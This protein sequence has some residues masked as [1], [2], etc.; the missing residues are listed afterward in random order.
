MKPTRWPAFLMCMALMVAAPAAAQ[1]LEPDQEAAAPAD[2]EVTAVVLR[3]FP[4]QFYMNRNA[5]PAGFA[6][7]VLDKV[8]ELAHLRIRYLIKN[9][10]EEA[11]EALRRGEGQI[12]PNMAMLPAWQREFD[13]SMPVEASPVS[14]FVL[15]T[16]KDIRATADLA[17]RKVAAVEFNAP[18]GLFRNGPQVQLEIFDSPLEGL[19]HLLAG[20]MDAFVYPQATLLGLA[21]RIGVDHR[22]QTVD[23]PL[24]QL[25]RA[26][27]LR[28]GNLQ[29]RERLDAALGQLVGGPEFKEIYRKW[30]GSPHPFWTISRVTW[31]MTALLVVALVVMALWR[32]LSI[33]AL[34]R[35]LLENIAVRR[36]AEEA[37]RDSEEKYRLVVEN[38]NEAIFVVQEG[39]IRFAN[40]VTQELTGYGASEL[41]NLPFLELVH[42]AD[43]EQA[44]GHQGQPAAGSQNYR[45]VGRQR[46]TRWVQVN[47]VDISWGNRPARLLLARDIT[48]QRTRE[49][50]AR[51]RQKIED[52]GALAGSVAHD[53]NKALGIIHHNVEM[54]LEQ[55]QPGTLSQ[56]ALERSLQAVQRSKDLV[57]EILTFRRLGRTPHHRLEMQPLVEDSLR[58]IGG[59]LPAG[60]GLTARLE[61]PGHWIEGDP[62]QV[63]Q[64]LMNLCLNAAQAIGVAGG[65]IEVGLAPHG[66]EEGRE[67]LHPGLTPGPYLLLSVRDTGQG[68]SPE[69]LPKI[70]D[71]FFTTKRPEEG[72]GLG[73][74][75]V[76]GIVQNH[77]GQVS[78]ESR[79]GQGTIFRLL[80]PRCQD[81]PAEE[82]SLPTAAATGATLPPPAGAGRLLLVDDDR[83]FLATQQALLEEAGFQVRTVDDPRRALE[84]VRTGPRAFDLVISDLNMPG[85]DGLELVR[86]LLAIHPGLPV[87]ICTGYGGDLDYR[88][89]LA[90]GARGVLDKTLS[91]RQLTE[92]IARTLAGLPEADRPVSGAAE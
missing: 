51:Q 27:A 12:I 82:A 88:Q 31:T 32:Y 4:P 7:D 83:Q 84:L 48:L 62:T 44:A 40:P 2:I 59:A 23:R 49:A 85:L 81:P 30:Y 71:P 35:H 67:A 41:D 70:F 57:R 29:L 5:Q 10:W 60:V 37:L 15:K 20:D 92:T 55:T 34:N 24:A 52:L 9:T 54:A 56:R 42:R 87:L 26:I 13:F 91:G 1:M 11:V 76:Q 66:V 22:I 79:P 53:F 90:T 75:V 50:Q 18:S 46:Q 47:S 38:A 17:G 64:V 61:A 78:V 58:Q 16:N 39:L 74:T 25:E 21:Q 86:R 73:L 77:G 63:H 19:F 43:R 65:T 6:I 45:L 69:A 28:K 33:M 80:W 89:V 36:S 8:A 68:I 3:Y 72:T 14:I